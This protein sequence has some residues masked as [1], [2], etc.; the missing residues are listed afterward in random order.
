LGHTRTI[1]VDRIPATEVT[2]E[3]ITDTHVTFDVFGRCDVLIERA[4]R[5]N[6]LRHQRITYTAADTD[7]PSEPPRPEE[8]RTA[9][10]GD[11]RQP[12]SSGGEVR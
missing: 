8:Q 11:R 1:T 12:S 7:G 5:A 4:L 10:R 3:G 9:R 6:D 2:Y